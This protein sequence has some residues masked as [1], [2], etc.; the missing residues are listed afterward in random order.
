MGKPVTKGPGHRWQD[1]IKIVLKEMGWVVVDWINVAS[2]CEYRYEYSN[3]IKCGI[4]GGGGYLRG[5]RLV[6][7]EGVCS[8]ELAVI[9]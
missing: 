3:F 6:S 5:Y 9:F 1:N 8:V 2:C 4:L 7:E